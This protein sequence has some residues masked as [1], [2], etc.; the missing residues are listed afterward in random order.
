MPVAGGR[1]HTIGG[2]DCIQKQRVLVSDWCLRA[3]RVRAS[4]VT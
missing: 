4:G 2:T 3:K 1:M